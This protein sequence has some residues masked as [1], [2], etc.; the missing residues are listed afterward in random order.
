MNK[1][2]RVLVK[3]YGYEIL[4]RDGKHELHRDG[5]CL[6]VFHTVLGC[7]EHLIPLVNDTEFARRYQKRYCR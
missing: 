5:R 3:D 6:G 1:A 7:V 4:D 2:M